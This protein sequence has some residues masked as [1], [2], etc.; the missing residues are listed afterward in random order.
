MF[1]NRSY[2][3][4]E[5]ENKVAIETSFTSLHARRHLYEW[6]FYLYEESN[7]SYQ[8]PVACFDATCPMIWSCFGNIFVFIHRENNQ[9]LKKS[10]MIM[11]W[12][13]HGMTKLSG[14]LRHWMYHKPRIHIFSIFAT[15]VISFAY[16]KA[17]RFLFRWKW[18]IWL[19]KYY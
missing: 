14:W 5:R 7:W 2:W 10:R 3:G 18:L 13:L 1:W 15:K 17:F 12:N 9:F 16:W 19:A 4:N 8:N 11:I 6:V